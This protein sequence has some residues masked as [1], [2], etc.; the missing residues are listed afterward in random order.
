M[1]LLQS[2]VLGAHANFLEAL[3]INYYKRLCH[4]LMHE[5]LEI[6][7]S[8]F[9]RLNHSSLSTIYFISLSSSLVGKD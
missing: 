2:L 3:K 8:A 4:L 1:W 9:S 6:Q 7:K 5:Y